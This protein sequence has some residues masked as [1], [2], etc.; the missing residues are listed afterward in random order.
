MSMKWVSGVPGDE[1]C[2]W[3]GLKKTDIKALES[4]TPARLTTTSDQLAGLYL[5][6]I[7][8]HRHQ[9]VSARLSSSCQRTKQSS[10]S[11]RTNIYQA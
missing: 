10:Q 6:A 11:M 5:L 1:R 2:T 3:T 7:L 4:C 8:E 9:P